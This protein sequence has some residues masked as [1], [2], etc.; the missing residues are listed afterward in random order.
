MSKVEVSVNRDRDEVEFFL[1]ESG[2]RTRVEGET[3]KR[4]HQAKA[5][6]GDDVSIRPDGTAVITTRA[7]P[8]IVTAV[9]DDGRLFPVYPNYSTG[10]LPYPLATGHEATPARGTYAA[11][12]ARQQARNDALVVDLGRRFDARKLMA[13][14]IDMVRAHNGLPD[15]PVADDREVAQYRRRFAEELRSPDRYD[16]RDQLVLTID[17][18][19]TKD[20]DDALGIEELAPHRYRLWVHIA[21]VTAFVSVDSDRD[22]NARSRSSSVYLADTVIHMLPTILSQ[23]LCSLQPNEDRLAF[24]VFSDLEL[25]EDGTLGELGK[26]G[27]LRTII[28]SAHRLTYDE[29]AAVLDNEV[30]ARA[31]A[32]EDL[33]RSLELIA[34]VSEALKANHRPGEYDEEAKYREDDSGRLHLKT[35]ERNDADSLI[36]VL[37]VTANRLVGE[38]LASMLR[39]MRP[40]WPVAFRHQPSATKGQV[41]EF[42]TRMFDAGLIPDDDLEDIRRVAVNAEPDL[43]EDER[44]HFYSSFVLNALFELVD[45]RNPHAVAARDALF[46]DQRGKRLIGTAKVTSNVNDTFHHGMRIRRYAWFTSPIRRYADVINHRALAASLAPVSPEPPPTVDIAKVSNATAKAKFAQKDLGHRLVV[47]WL[48]Q[49][50]LQSLH[51]SLR[52][53]RIAHGRGFVIEAR[54]DSPDLPALVVPILFRGF[55]TRIRDNRLDCRIGRGN[56]LLEL[57]V[58][59]RLSCRLGRNL[60]EVRPDLGVLE[61]LQ[62]DALTLET[63][64]G[65][66]PPWHD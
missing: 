26:C 63:S 40:G 46:L 62:L 14:E 23:E 53:F 48:A 38:E 61:V 1:R 25:N 58:G 2:G 43:E 27:F 10:A 49:Q 22:R 65:P 15:E 5:L 51:L 59:D 4:L 32:P 66:H 13:R 19:D 60:A 12:I 29:V 54:V 3:S 18:P 24:S 47:H 33:V 34:R 16:L 35:R 6:R 44:Q 45:N 20:I 37:M 31:K 17:G 7:D 56:R 39:L 9:E 8:H 41:R 64:R 21:D 57:A 28:R 52:G 50:E 36:E 55:S 11:T 42:A 30:G